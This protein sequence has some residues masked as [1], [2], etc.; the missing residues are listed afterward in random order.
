MKNT[1]FQG[2]A[3]A[4]IT[5]FKDG[6]VDY[7]ALENILEFQIAGGIDALVV[8][9]TTGEPATLDDD[10]H[11]KVVEFAIEKVN[12]RVPVIAGTGSN[13]TQYAVELSRFAEK[14]GAD[15]LLLVTPYYNKC[16]QK[17]IVSHFNT[18]ADSVNIP[19]IVY[20]VP[21]RTGFCISIDSYKQIA[22]HENIVA[23]KEASGNL[24]LMM[25]VLEACGN[26]IN[27][28]SG[29][30]QQIVPLMSMGAIG[31]I[32]VFS[33]VMPA[34]AHRIT[35]LCL[36]G[37]FK[38]A[39]QLQLKYLRLMNG[40]FMQVNPIPVKTAMAK[41]GFCDNEFRMPLCPMDASDDEKLFALMREQGLCK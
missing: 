41:M 20:N 19:C 3:T 26:D 7:A 21:G 27:M 31:V 33:N 14:A 15:G 37:D 1:I 34:E 9:G 13:N 16:S 23:T 17:G 39:A 5:P 25:E 36:D 12:H 8:C 30:D 2:A 29:D 28:Y 22:K 38:T 18:V 35:K 24:L 10:E 40:L 32:S 4:L 11:K 6:K